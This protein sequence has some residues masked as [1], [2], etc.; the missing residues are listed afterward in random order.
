MSAFPTATSSPPSTRSLLASVR[1]QLADGDGWLSVPLLAAQWRAAQAEV[2]GW[3]SEL[4]DLGL[5]AGTPE[6]P[7]FTI[8][9]EGLRFLE[10]GEPAG[11][12]HG[13]P[14]PLP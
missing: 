9:A 3:L 6:A 12:E 2:V 14:D 8:T 11:D 13:G 7:Y 5:F 4:M 1:S 10:Q